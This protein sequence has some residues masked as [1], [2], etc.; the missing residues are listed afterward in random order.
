MTR[1]TGPVQGV[2]TDGLAGV[3][4]PE[5]G[6]LIV[7]AGGDASPGHDAAGEA[8]AVSDRDVVPDGAAPDPGSAA[9]VRSAEDGVT[10]VEAGGRVPEE[11]PAACVEVS[12]ALRERSAALERFE[13]R[14]EEIA[15]AAEVVKRAIMEDPADL[16]DPVVEE[17]LPEVCHQRGLA[18][19]DAGED[20]RSQGANAG[21]QERAW[22]V[23]AEGR[24]TVP[25]GLQR[26]V[27]V[28]I[29]ILREEQ[30]RGPAQGP[31]AG[32]EAGKVGGDGGVGIHD[33][34]IPAGEELRGVTKRSR[35][36]EDARLR[37]KRELQKA[38]RLLAQVALDL[39]TEVMKI[40][41]HFSDA[42]LLEPPKM[43]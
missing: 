6:F 26:R 32:E 20:P 33:Q 16:L 11:Q 39:I 34:K 40:N 14:A 25:F 19:G 23:D 30:R 8:G 35:R 28:R 18:R 22:S 5:K 43:R 12:A 27:V 2:G 21:V 36:S 42:G 29:P 31:M 41:C 1:S 4:G 37:E 7:R 13:R 24:D 3:G 10:G 17:R 9:E 38:R 15:R